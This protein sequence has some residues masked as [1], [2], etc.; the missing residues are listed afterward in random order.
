MFYL[1]G[2]RPSGKS[3]FFLPWSS[4]SV[5]E[6]ESIFFS[7]RTV[8]LDTYTPTPHLMEGPINWTFEYQTGLENFDPHFGRRP[9]RNWSYY[10]RK[11]I[12]L[13]IFSTWCQITPHYQRNIFLEGFDFV[14]FLIIFIGKKIS[15][16]FRKYFF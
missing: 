13:R 15:Q 2:R 11:L 8:P 3:A 16:L 5:I 9:E 10:R 4:Q 14:S 7:T 1:L 12:F 6:M